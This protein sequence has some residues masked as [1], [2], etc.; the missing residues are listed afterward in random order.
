[1]ALGEVPRSLDGSSSALL[2][3][4]EEIRSG[5]RIK[6]NG[7]I[8][9]SIARSA[10]HTFFTE[11]EGK[12]TIAVDPRVYVPLPEHPNSHGFERLAEQLS[13]RQDLSLLLSE[14]VGHHERN[15]HFFAANPEK[16]IRLLYSP[17]NNGHIKPIGF[18]EV[19]L[20]SYGHADFIGII[21]DVIIFIIEFGQGGKSAQL[22][23]YIEGLRNLFNLPDATI[24]PLIVNYSFSSNNTRLSVVPPSI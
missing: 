24:V 12:W 18:S 5:F 2:A 3:E 6:P 15:I 20:G 9:A 22:R 7:D 8:P 21:P 19:N 10:E 4:L 13:S 1:M 16:V 17:G 23:R 14:Q 11:D